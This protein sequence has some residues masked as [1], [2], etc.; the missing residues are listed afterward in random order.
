MKIAFAASR[1]LS[2]DII[3]WIHNNKTKYNVELVGG[4]APK[5]KGWWDDKV[6]ETYANLEI[7]IYS[8]I[9]EMIDDSKPEIVFSLNYWRIISPEYIAKVD[10]G[11]INIHHSYKLRFRGR[12][13]TSWAIIHARKDDNWW[14]GTTLH[15]VDSKLDNGYI[16]A[17]ERCNIYENDT[18]EILFERVENLA[19]DMFKNSFHKILNGVNKFIE[20]DSNF[21][22]YGI[23]SNNNLEIDFNSSIEEVYD[24]VRAWSFKDRPKPYIMFEG[25]KIELSINSMNIETNK[26]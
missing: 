16:I 25:N 13:S 9:E 20:P 12:Y 5:F 24:F 21:F 2:V 18:A 7:P 8:S 23:D 26:N 22:Y 15:Y 1:N 4:V 3:Q 17:S 19:V 10:K 14:H 6:N 11:I